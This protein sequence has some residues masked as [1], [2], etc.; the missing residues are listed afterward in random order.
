MMAFTQ[1]E[2][3]KV[4][5]VESR[6]KIIELLREKG[7]LAVNE[8]AEA[9]GITAS[10][11]SQH[12]KIL[13]YAGLVRSERKGYWLPYDIDHAAL[14]HCRALITE[15]CDCGCTGTCRAE[16][17]NIKGSKNELSLLKKHEREIRRELK[18]VQARIKEIRDDK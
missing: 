10:A 15:V 11:V 6:L 8:L 7:P 4:L 17:M 9:M 1:A 2:L 13:R 16:Q 5:S 12:L 18:A 3:F 14:A